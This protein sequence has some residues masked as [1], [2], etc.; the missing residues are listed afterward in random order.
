MLKSIEHQLSKIQ[1]KI[2]NTLERN[3]LDCQYL[4]TLSDNLSVFSYSKIL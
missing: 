2:P 3:T 4:D 1:E